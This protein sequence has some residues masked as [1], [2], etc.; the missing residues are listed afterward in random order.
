MFTVFLSGTTASYHRFNISRC[1]VLIVD[2]TALCEHRR[3]ELLDF[4]VLKL[5]EEVIR[6]S[7]IL[8]SLTETLRILRHNPSITKFQI[9]IFE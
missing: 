6:F 1:F 4:L 2:S 7:T 8:E 9:K 5:D 3:I